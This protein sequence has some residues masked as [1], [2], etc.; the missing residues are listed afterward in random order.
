MITKAKR[1]TRAF[2]LIEVL[3]GVAIFA[4]VLSA[5]NGV[6]YGAMRLRSKT[7]RMVDQ[8]LPITQALAY[9]KRDLEGINP[10]TGTLSPGLK[11]GNVTGT[12]TGAQGATEL[13]TVT[14]SLTD[15]A[16]WGNMQKVVYTLRDSNN[17]PGHAGRDLFRLVTRNL[18]AP[19][20]E[21]PAEQFLM[22]E[23]E[24]LQ[25]YFFDGTQWLNSWDS[26]NEV[27]ALPRAIKVQLNLA[28]NGADRPFK[29][30]Y[31]LVVPVASQMRSNTTDTATAP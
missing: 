18:L 5:I 31:E 14:G 23:V 1:V 24:D 6:F 22:S 25:F 2:T 8:A 20:Q 7:V 19:M 10:P 15:G 13:Y 29:A 3:L 21:D 26:T 17:G 4:I 28:A 9:L 12:M 11:S 30:F 27:S 16:P